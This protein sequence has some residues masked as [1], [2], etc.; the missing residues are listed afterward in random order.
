MTT[1]ILV[2]HG[3]VHNPNHVVYA[4]LPGFDLSACGVLE[5]HAAAQKL[6]EID[7]DAVIASPLPRALHTATAIAR[8]H[9]LGVVVDQRL[10]ETRMYP[11]W[12]GLRWDDVQ[13]RYARQFDGYLRDATAL[14]DV[15]ESVEQ[16]AA[17]MR[18]AAETALASGAHSIAM[19]GHQDPIQALRL[20]LLSRPLALL[21][22]N[23][24]DHGSLTV[25][26]TSNGSHWT[27]QSYWKPT[28]RAQTLNRAKAGTLPTP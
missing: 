8:R 19:V 3:E 5:A 12:T 15:S 1:L 14:D 9:G 6:S 10:V 24:P 13:H 7:L 17:R 2:R 22:T 4:D 21:R 23:T 25:L 16:V 26:T 18:D 20:T 11:Q 28:N 27:E